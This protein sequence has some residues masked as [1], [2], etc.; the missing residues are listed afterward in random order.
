MFDLTVGIFGTDRF[1]S[2]GRRLRVATEKQA[3][4]STDL[5]YDKVQENL[6]G[7]ILQKRTGDLAASIHKLYDNTGD[8]YIGEVYVDPADDKAKALEYGGKGYYTIVPSKGEFLKFYW[9]K[10]GS[11]VFARSVN[12]PPSKAYHY[13]ALALEDLRDTIPQGFREAIQTTLD[14]EL[15]GGGY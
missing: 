6:S 13:L 5:L 12:H 3:I 4:K 11:V 14:G 9:E 8:G 1:D 15:F 7:R 10:M 2:L